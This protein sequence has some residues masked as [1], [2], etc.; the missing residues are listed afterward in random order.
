MFIFSLRII[1]I[2]TIMKTVETVIAVKIGF[3]N[4]RLKSWVNTK[5]SDYLTV[6]TVYQNLCDFK[7]K[8]ALTL[9][10]NFK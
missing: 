3:L 2:F 7:S 1:F 6:L 8:L 9:Q 10:K 4:P 5:E